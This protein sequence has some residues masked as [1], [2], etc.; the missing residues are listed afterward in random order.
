[1]EKKYSKKS[2]LKKISF[3]TLAIFFSALIY[4]VHK[5][6]VDALT[7]IADEYKV[8]KILEIEPGD[9]FKLTKTEGK[10]ID[11]GAYDDNKI[12]IPRNEKING[13]VSGSNVEITHITMPEFISMVD[14]INGQYD[15]VIIGRENIKSKGPNEWDEVKGLSSTYSY[16]TK[17]IDYTNP[18]STALNRATFPSS[19]SEVEY[20]SEND[21]TDKRKQEIEKMIKS[22]QLVYI[23]N[24]IGADN[25]NKKISWNTENKTIKNTKLYSLYNSNNANNFKKVNLDSIILESIINEYKNSSN[26]YSKR[27][28]INEEANL[29]AN[30]DSSKNIKFDF[31]VYNDT[32]NIK[33][34]LYLDKNGDGL[35]TEDECK[36]N[37]SYNSSNNS[38]GSKHY[39]IS[40]KLDDNLWGYLGWKIEVIN[41]IY[42]DIPIKTNVVG[43]NI[44]KR[45]QN[46]PKKEIK[47][48]QLFPSYWN[49][50]SENDKPKEFQ[51]N[52]AFQSLWNTISEDYNISIVRTRIDKFDKQILDGTETLKNKY[53][54]VIIG[55][56]K[57]DTVGS[58][59]DKLS[60]KTIQE[61]EDYIKS[62]KSLI[63][64][65]DTMSY[66]IPSLVDGKNT[67]TQAFRDGIG[68]ARFKDPF[69]QDELDVYGKNI[70]H[71]NIGEQ[72][73]YSAGMAARSWTGVGKN[74]ADN[75]YYARNVNE[76]QITSYPFDLN[77]RNIEVSKYDRTQVYQ[78]NLEDQ[79]VVPL[80]NII[81]DGYGAV[82]SGESRNFYHSYS[83]GNITYWASLPDF[84]AWNPENKFPTDELK[85]FINTIINTQSNMQSNENL[86]PK[87]NIYADLDESRLKKIDSSGNLLSSNVNGTTIEVN[88]GDNVNVDYKITPA[89]LLGG[90][91]K[92]SEYQDVAVLIDNSITNNTWA[93][94]KNGLNDTLVKLLNDSKYMRYD[95]ILFG[96]NGAEEYKKG[97]S[98]TELRDNI[99]KANLGNNI[100]RESVNGK[101]NDAIYKSIEFFDDSRSPIE[102]TSK[103]IIVFSRKNVEQIDETVKS[104]IKENYNVITIQ[105]SDDDSEGLNL[106]TIHNTLGGL[107]SD[108]YVCNPNKE[109]TENYNKSADEIMNT[110]SGNISRMQYKTYILDNVKLN[111]NLGNNIDL[112][113]NGLTQSIA[114][115]K[116]YYKVLPRIKYVVDIDQGGN[117][118]YKGEFIENSGNTVESYLV[119]FKIKAANNIYGLCEFDN[120]NEI[121]YEYFGLGSDRSTN[122]IDE[123]PKLQINR[124][125]VGHGVYKG[126]SSDTGKAVIDELN[127]NDSSQENSLKF[128]IDSVVPFAANIDTN[129]TTNDAKLQID[130]DCEFIG[131]ISIYSNGKVIHKIETTNKTKMYDFTNY[132]KSFSNIVIMYNVKL[133]STTKTH[134]T[135]T[136]T[137]DGQKFD[138]YIRTSN[139]QLPDLF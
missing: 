86:L 1:M 100:R 49:D 20:Y 78:L 33:V 74:S 54:V 109:A 52:L 130:S 5:I 76:S 123:T 96:E 28:Y 34:N 135:N 126:M 106:K 62:G 128:A 30:I 101:I 48:L 69:N 125:S 132:I 70:P 104:L 121:T 120:P 64:T 51:D 11:P 103:N 23:D 87:F 18:F 105:I 40:Y 65:A 4:S 9:I 124:V 134:Y 63:F 50:Y 116:K 85:F 138:A 82:N 45:P 108:Y 75:K 122:I 91:I 114:N 61:I 35:Y 47:I 12:V 22:N 2:I 3:F 17:Y 27:I 24:K 39:N 89:S 8:I 110:V 16:N 13:K 58:Y 56:G 139:T 90:N 73:K 98:S 99:T 19:Y 129:N 77:G 60:N 119:N 112:Y 32:G 41:N 133:K 117:L 137:T 42:N 43:S 21:L 15:I 71:M 53:N 46:I 6:N 136:I 67:L 84:D 25:Y 83:K 81:N 93:K 10:S 26:N 92:K 55:F 115:E 88:S 118:I 127:L 111:F 31:N 36:S 68:Q 107:N 57:N 37:I 14:E 38:D 80:Y 94:F 44:I 59:N 102:S 7:S 72:G 66:Q 79:E 29:E 113:G 97:N 95:L 131:L